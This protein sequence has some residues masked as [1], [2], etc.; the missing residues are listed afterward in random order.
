M[1]I[2]S[3]IT[4]T[5]LSLLSFSFQLLCKKVR[6]FQSV[7]WQTEHA[8]FSCHQSKGLMCT[9]Q[10]LNLLWL[11]LW[12]YLVQ[13]LPPPFP[14]ILVITQRVRAF[15]ITTVDPHLTPYLQSDIC[16]DCF[17]SIKKSSEILLRS[18]CGMSLCS[19]WLIL[20]KP[21]QG[22]KK[23]YERLIQLQFCKIK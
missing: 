18:H 20:N 12:L 1:L 9:V 16:S 15:L 23:L 19:R 4:S 6:V 17:T 13:S 21:L 8:F 3:L 11:Q 7:I 10:S 5:L 2:L 22:N 14:S